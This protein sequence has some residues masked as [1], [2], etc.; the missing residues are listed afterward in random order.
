MEILAVILII[1]S[2]IKLIAISSL[3]STLKIEYTDLEIY[4]K[5][6]INVLI[7]DGLIGVLCGIYILL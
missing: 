6:I 4:K 2:I 1:F 5:S 7:L 3:N